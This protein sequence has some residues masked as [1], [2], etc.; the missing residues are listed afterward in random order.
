M[1]PEFLREGS[2]IEDF[3]APPK[4]VIGE[5][6]SPSGD[7]VARAYDGI[8]APVVRTSLRSAEMVKYADNAFHALKITFANEIGNI[9][10]AAGIDGREIMEIFRLDTKLNISGAY[11]KPGG[12][13][14][15]SCLPKDLRA[16]SYHA[17]VHDVRALLLTSI[18][19]SNDEQKR[20]ALELV[21]RTGKRRVG[22]LGLSFKPDTDDLRESPAVE[23]AEHL[24]GKGFRVSIYDRN[25]A[26]ARLIGANR[27]YI[28]R[29]IPHI[30][31]L[32]K[33]RVEDVVEESDVLVITNGD[34]EF[35]QLRGNGARGRIVIDLAGAVA[36]KSDGD[37]AGIC[38]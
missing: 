19:Q 17:R 25:V 6:D 4:I 18:L 11:L 32:M 12:A 5:I 1:N 34:P 31:T 37:Y 28:E 35:K 30:S 38:W 2:S 8:D 26:I 3:N 15:G 16:L 20:I 7:A 23:L 33:D 14:G 22:I 29:E 9:C 24:L 36:G 27:A 21:R 10:K 13:F